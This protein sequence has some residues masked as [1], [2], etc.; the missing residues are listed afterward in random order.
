MRFSPPSD[1]SL[2]RPDSLPARI[3][4]LPRPPQFQERRYEELSIRERYLRIRAFPIGV[5]IA[6]AIGALSMWIGIGVMVLACTLLTC[7]IAGIV[8]FS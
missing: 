8:L 5:Q 4:E 3:E 1:A 6:I 7:A 2:L